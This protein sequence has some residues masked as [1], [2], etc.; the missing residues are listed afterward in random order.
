[1]DLK[2]RLQDELTDEEL[3]LLVTSFD[4]VG[5]VAIIKVPDELAGKQDVIAEA[6]MEQHP[7]VRTVLKKAGDR[8]GEFRTA[9]YENLTGGPTETMHREHGC[10]FRLDPTAVYFSERLGHE[11]QRVME[12]VS[13]DETVIDMFAGIGPF[14]VLIARNR[15]ATVHAFEKNPAAADYLAANV[16]LNNVD[17]LVDV[18]AGDVRAELAGLDVAGDRVI[19]NLPGSSE[20]FLDVALDHV[21]PGGTIHLYRFVAKDDLESGE[22]RADVER[23]FAEH[24]A[25]IDIAA[26]EV[27]GHYNPAVERVCF[28]VTVHDPGR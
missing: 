9:S 20:D 4:I 13:A 27:C 21:K 8:E 26:V 16:S 5:D 14:A 23:L 15:G 3:D 10:R 28:D 24:G 25:D 7:H 2:D 22:G 12:Q 11:R 1:M 6:V 19:M 17:D 18:Y